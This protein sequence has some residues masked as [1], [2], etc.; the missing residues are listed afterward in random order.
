MKVKDQFLSLGS[1]KVNNGAQT[2]FWEDVWLG[3]QPLKL[4]FPSLF[5]V[6]RRKQDTVAAVLNS[7]PP[8]VS[9]RRVLRGQNL[10]NWNRIVSS[11]ADVQLSEDPYFFHWSLHSSGQFSIKSIYAALVN[12]GVSVSQ[13][14]WHA[15]L[16]T[17]IKVFMWYLKRG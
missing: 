7:T 1:F 17:K 16:P 11:I 12:N 10:N 3:N 2:R 13:D 6:V 9:F 4:K 15:K 5:N 8:N 14:I